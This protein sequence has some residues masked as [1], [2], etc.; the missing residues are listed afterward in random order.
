MEYLIE[1]ATDIG[2]VKGVNQDSFMAKVIET[3]QGKI[4]FAVLCDGMGGLRS[5]EIASASVVHAY[6][7]WLENEFRTIC[8]SQLQE[9]ELQSSMQKIAYEFNEKI[10]TYGAERGIKLGTTLTTFLIIRDQYYIIHIGD[11]R[12]YEISHNI[13]MLTKDQTFV[14]RELDM[15]RLTPEQAQND[16]RSSILLQC[17]GA[18]EN[19]YPD[20]II[21]TAKSECTYL[22][23]SDGFRHKI[24]KEEM[25]YYLEPDK[26][27]SSNI[28]KQSINRLIDLNKQRQESDNITAIVIRTYN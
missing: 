27:L 3:N 24:T 22:L 15:G 23:C 16:P 2:N 19:I 21:G 18:S 12:V 4:A 6:N 8:E 14:Q 5:G 10:K 1:G 11:T 17:I 9:L 13:C 26:L 20:F 7:D 25:Q 28:I